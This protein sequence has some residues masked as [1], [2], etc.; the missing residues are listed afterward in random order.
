MST[1]CPSIGSLPNTNFMIGVCYASH[2]R[3]GDSPKGVG[4]VKINQ[5]RSQR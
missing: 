2:Q 4:E 1:S 3:H 5:I